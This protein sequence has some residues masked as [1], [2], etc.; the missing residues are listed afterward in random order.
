M[1]ELRKSGDELRKK[2]VKGNLFT[3]AVSKAGIR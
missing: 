1:D 3:A 2:A